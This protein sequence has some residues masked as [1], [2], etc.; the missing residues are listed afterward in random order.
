MRI[1]INRRDVALRL[2]KREAQCNRSPAAANIEN[3]ASGCER[4]EQL[5]VVEEYGGCL[6]DPIETEQT[7]RAHE[8]P[9]GTSEVHAQVA[10]L[11]VRTG[12]GREVMGVACHSKE[13]SG[14]EREKLPHRVRT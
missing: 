5:R 7:L 13:C 6:V 10:A 11:Q 9:L 8:A 2:G 4:C 12:R 3:L 14:A 1:D